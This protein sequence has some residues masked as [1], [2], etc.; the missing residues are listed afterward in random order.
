MSW[1][2]NSRPCDKLLIA[3]GRC[4]C[5]FFAMASNGVDAMWFPCSALN[6][7]VRYELSEGHQKTPRLLQ[8]LIVLQLQT[9][10]SF[11]VASLSIFSARVS[12]DS[13]VVVRFKLD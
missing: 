3:C 11:V 12:V 4:L 1:K 9:V 5:V 8:M 2:V 13:T 7:R 6:V 10:L